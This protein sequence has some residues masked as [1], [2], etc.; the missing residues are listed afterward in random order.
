MNRLRLIFALVPCLLLAAPE[1]VQ[2]AEALREVKAKNLEAAIS[3]LLAIIDRAPAF[4]RAH[5][6]VGLLA[7][8]AGRGQEVAA[9]LKLSQEP[10]A[11]YG[12][13]ELLLAQARSLKRSPRP[14]RECGP[15]LASCRFMTSGFASSGNCAGCPKPRLLWRI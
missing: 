12:L 5:K 13:A 3:G 7:I 4:D 10:Y 2:Y 15:R 6:T 11:Q 14:K 8:R 9:R 1:H